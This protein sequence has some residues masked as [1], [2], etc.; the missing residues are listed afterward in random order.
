MRRTH[1]IA[2][3][4][5]IFALSA[6]AQEAQR[7]LRFANTPS[8]NGMMEIATIVRSMTDIRD[9]SVDGAQRS[10]TIR[11]AGAAVRLGEWLFNQLDRPPGTPR[12]EEFT[13][14][15]DSQEPAIRIHFLAGAS[16]QDL[17]EIATVIRAITETRRVFT[18]PAMSAIVTRG[19]ADQ[20]A[21]AK[22]M[23]A[24][25]ERTAAATPEYQLKAREG[26]IRV[27]ELRSLTSPQ[28]TQEAATMLRS[29]AD[30]RWTFTVHSRKAIVIRGLPQQLLLAEW[31][32]ERADRAAPI[33]A[34]RH[35]FTMAAS[36]NERIY[37][38]LAVRAYVLAPGTPPARVQELAVSIRQ[39]AQL[40]RVMTQSAPPI[41]AFRGTEDQVA[42][43]DR[44]LARQLESK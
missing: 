36:T 35:S 9:L 37:P 28:Q 3:G 32:I 14:Q 44:L 16:L 11:G 2:L 20:A 10:I 39:R 8:A 6:F 34:A 43:A 27:V 12:I 23:L 13:W 40:R 38:E 33:P 5:A 42:E 4:S 15:D 18:Y 17:Q 21:A 19:T 30:M 24:R 26:T 1:R 41:L 31:L 25:L 7:E 29:L 22:W